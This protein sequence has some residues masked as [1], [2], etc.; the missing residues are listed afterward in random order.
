MSFVAVAGMEVTMINRER[1]GIFSVLAAFYRNANSIGLAGHVCLLAI[2]FL[3]LC[4][5]TPVSA[6]TQLG[7]DIENEM[8]RIESNASVS[9]SSDGSRLAVGARDNDDNGS[10]SGH[11]RVHQWSG[12]TWV[13]LGADIDGEAVEDFSGDV[14][15][16]SSDGNR[17]AIGAH[18]NDGNGDYS[19]HV[20][21]YQW[22]GADWTQLGSDIDGEAAGDQSGLTISLSSD[23][24]RLAI[25]ATENDG[26]GDRSGHVRVY[27]WS[28]TA[29][30]QLGIDIDG[31]AAGDR[32][33]HSV[34]LSSDGNRLAIG[35][36][37]NDG[38]GDY[39]GHVRV[40]QWSGTTWV[41]LGANIIGAAANEFFGNGVSL[42]SSGNRLAVGATAFDY[43][44]RAGLVRIYQWSGTSWEQLGA[45]IEGEADGDNSGRSISLSADGNRLAIGASHNSTNA[46]R[47]GQVR[48]FQWTGSAWM[49]LGS[50]INSYLIYDYFGKHVSLSSDGNR[51]ASATGDMNAIAER[52]NRVRVYDLSMFNTFRINAGHSG[53]WFN[54]DTSGQG[55]LIDVI[56]EDQYMFLAWFTFTDAASANPDQQHW[57]TAQ[58]NYSGNTAELIL[59]ETLGGQFDDPQ[60]TSTNPVGTVTVSFSD[61]EQGQMTY[62]IDTDGR[63]GTIPLT[64]LIPGSENICEDKG[65]KTTITTEAVDIN[66]GMDGAWVNTDTLGQGF[67]IDAHPNPDGSNFIFVAWFTYGDDTASGQRWLTAQGDF[68]GSIAEMDIHETTGGSF[69]AA[70]LVDVNQVGTMTIDFTDCSNAQLSYTLTDDGIDGDMELSRLIPGGQ[71]LCEELAGAD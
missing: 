53:A 13:Q 42:S 36:T 57:Y 27:D 35:A 39:S 49:Q 28:G 58:G 8:S 45:D 10:R 18:G 25:G 64:R 4:L 43:R 11:V 56:P 41:Q 67:L 29:W 51:V 20:R 48:I 21:V 59:H 34:S 63:Q 40:Y 32:S 17:L 71:A 65:G 22:S 66:A 54:P 69:D 31:E 47:S 19:G 2:V 6:Q 46:E 3:N 12:T 24:N 9:L 38:N 50:N 60:E 61:C 1:F 68:A 52:L 33:G 15:S 55:Q 7:A 37:S 23:G 16:L 5:S 62:S 70:Q 30:A 26:N 14:V 44:D